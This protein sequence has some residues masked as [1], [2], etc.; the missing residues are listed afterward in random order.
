MKKII[1]SKPCTKGFITRL[2]PKK[3]FLRFFRELFFSSRYTPHAVTPWGTTLPP[4]V[5]PWGTT[6]PAV[7]PLGDYTPPCRAIFFLIFFR[8]KK[9]TCFSETRPY[10]VYKRFGTLKIFFSIFFGHFFFGGDSLLRFFC[11]LFFYGPTPPMQS[12][13]GLLHP[14]VGRR[15]FFSNFFSSQ[16]YFFLLKNRHMGDF[17]GRLGPD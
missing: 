10:G 17:F 2:G 9:K 3:I 8:L 7:P 13:P 6:P 15:F 14:P 1:F 12:P 5:T 16:K 11:E 4:A